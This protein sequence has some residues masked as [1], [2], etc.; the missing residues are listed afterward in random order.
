MVLNCGSSSVKYAIFDDGADK[1]LADGIVERIGGFKSKLKHRFGGGAI[2]EQERVV[3]NH[4]EALKIIIDLLINGTIKNISEISAVGHRIVHGGEKINRPVAIDGKVLKLLNECAEL[5]PLHMPHN[6]LGINVC[7]RILRHAVQVAVFDTDFHQTIPDYAY[8]YPIPYEYYEK[9]KVRKYG[10]HG[11]SHKY[12][13]KR[14]A[15]ILNVN[16][17]ELKIISCHLGNGASLCAIKNGKSLD[18]TMGFTPL[19]GLMMGTRCGDIDPAVVLYL[20]EKEGTCLD[21]IARILNERSGVLG[22]SG[23][24]SDFRDLEKAA[25][26]GSD[27]ALLAL[28]MFI[29][30][31]AKG[32]GSFIPVLGGLDVLIFT[33]GVGENSSTIR[34]RVCKM[35]QCLGIELDE[36]LNLEKRGIEGIISTPA[37][38]VKV[39]VIPTDEEK[40]I[41]KE[42]IKVAEEV[43]TL[44]N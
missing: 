11:I 5:A 17:E 42:T 13:A 38:D 32:I 18:T 29:Y 14:A 44:V 37:S 41:A 1:V 8:I 25:E 12:V 43:F 19:A 15:E 7:Q 24:S 21:E 31:V 22:I 34:S 35:L 27:K 36:H 33:A 26:K 39:I 23:L 16:I 4:E 6:I 10:F 40:L 3:P 2:L 20:M 30:R 9:Y 28:E